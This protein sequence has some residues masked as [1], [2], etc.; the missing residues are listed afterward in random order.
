MGRTLSSI[1]NRPFAK[2]FG[3]LFAFALLA[4]TFCLGLASCS[5]NTATVETPDTTAN[6]AAESVIGLVQIDI[7]TTALDGGEVETFAVNL[8]EN[9]SAFDALKASG[10]AYTSEDSV[11]GTLITSI[12]GIKQGE[13]GP[14]SGWL[15]YLGGEYAPTSADRLMLKDGDV[16]TWVFTTGDDF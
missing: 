14:M 3:R 11:Y 16:V 13:H 5:P 4:L 15:F 7:D 9:M 2:S 6:T 8:T 10:A 12:K 1:H